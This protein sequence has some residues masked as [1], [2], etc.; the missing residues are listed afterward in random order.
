VSFLCPVFICFIL[1]IFGVLSQFKPGVSNPNPIWVKWTI[2][3]IKEGCRSWVN[4]ICIV[5]R[6]WAG[7]FLVWILAGTR[8]FLFSKMSRLSVWPR[9]PP[10]K[11]MLTLLSLAVKW[12]GCEADHSSPSGAEV[13][14]G[15]T[16]T[17]SS[18]IC[19]H[20]LYRYNC[21]F[22]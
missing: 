12:P 20:S 5:M 18:L 16:Y 3:K 9:N 22:Y 15:W 17:S 10:I 8:N 11:W 7:L 4:V 1:I 14:N 21:T 6:L 19:F 2:F 13:K